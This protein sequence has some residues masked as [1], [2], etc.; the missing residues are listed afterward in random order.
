MEEDN[1]EERMV[2]GIVL[3]INI[4]IHVLFDSLCTHLFIALRIVKELAL[5]TSTLPYP[6]RFTVA[7]GEL[8]FISV[9][10]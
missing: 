7:R 2:R 8:E 4:K 6:L 5:K 10:T 1:N 9:T 3:I